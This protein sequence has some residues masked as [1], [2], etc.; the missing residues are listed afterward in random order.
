[1]FFFQMTPENEL[2]RANI[3][4]LAYSH[5]G[6]DLLCSYNDEDIYIFDA[7][8]SSEADYVHKYTG[9]RNSATGMVTAV[10]KVLQEEQ[11]EVS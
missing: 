11:L 1:M 10:S 2:K 4:C 8:H 6:R 7:T 3:T 5:D 9:H